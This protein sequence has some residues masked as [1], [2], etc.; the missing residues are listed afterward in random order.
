[1]TC[2]M[3]MFARMLVWA[4]VAAPDVAARQAHAQVRPRGLTELVALL[5]FAGCERVRL[6]R[7]TLVGC[8]VFTRIGDRHGVG[9]IP[10]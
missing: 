3:E 6:H 1:M 9:V 2:G 10:A 7:G 5:A 4:G 8:A